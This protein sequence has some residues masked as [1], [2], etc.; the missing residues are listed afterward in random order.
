MWMHRLCKI[1]SQ[2]KGGLAQKVWEPL[3]QTHKIKGSEDGI[4]LFFVLLVVFL[5][6]FYLEG[7]VS[8]HCYAIVITTVACVFKCLFS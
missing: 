8:G 7:I 2:Y 3:I 5:V 6:A 1:C 4:S